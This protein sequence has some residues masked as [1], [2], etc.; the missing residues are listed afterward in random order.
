MRRSIVA[1]SLA[2][3]L[4][5]LPAQAQQRPPCPEGRTFAG[6][7]VEPGR[8][9]AMRRSAVA[10]T[11]LRISYMSPPWLPAHDR[12]LYVTK[13]FHEMNNIFLPPL[14]FRNTGIKP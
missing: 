11:Q 4:I 14:L 13:N 5:G 2:L 3:A 6:D 8:A 1:F 12:G 7:C 10:N 9:A